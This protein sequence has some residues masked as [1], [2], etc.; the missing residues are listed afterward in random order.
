MPRPRNAQELIH[1]IEEGAGARGIWRAALLAGILVLSLV[2]AWKQFHGPV[3]ESTL[4]QADLGRQLARGE[5][6]TTL[7]N[8]PQTMAFL[9]ARGVRFDPRQPYP[10][11]Y[12]APLYSLAIA[13]ALRLL[14][15]STRTALFATAPAPPDGFGGDYFLLGLNLVLLWLAAWQTYDLG[16]RLFA[17]RV[18]GLAAL[19]LLVSVAVWQQTVAVNGTVLLMVLVLAAFQIWQRIEAAA[20]AAGRAS[21]GWL[22]ALGAVGG[23]L[24]LAEY[25]AGALLL[26]ALGYAGGRFGGRARAVALLAVMVGAI[27]I[28]APWLVRNMRIAGNPVALAAYNLALKAGDPTADPATLR[29]TLSAEAPPLS[30]NKLGNKALTALQETLKSRLWAGGGMFLTAFFVAGWLY[31]FRSRTANRLRWLFVVAFAVLLVAQAGCNSGESECQPA[32][33]L[34]PLV[35][36]FG[37]G[38]FYVLVESSASMVAWPHLAGAVLLAVQ[39]LPLAHDALEPR[40]LHFQY[41]PYFPVQFVGLRLELAQRDPAGRY[42]LMADVPAGAAWYGQL[43]TWAQPLRLRDFYAITFT[44]SIAELLLTPRTLDRPF[45]SE[46]SARPILPEALTAGPSRFGEWG[47]IYAGFLTGRLPP[48]FPLRVPKKWAENL[49]VLYDATLPAPR[50]K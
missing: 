32:V 27:A 31:G 38:F 22:A 21:A 12:H 45:F 7:V 14:P 49:Y 16:R 41:P 5:G 39:A 34:A 23:L 46:L 3:S 18:G 8:Y 37:A 9:Q 35:M 11:L 33:Y 24:F 25:S 1:W 20:D 17:P 2:V 30:L 47:Q 42:G 26:V 50:E 28:T 44:Q 43:R 13:A 15:A 6:F 40:R 4:V 10:E 19:A 36:I 48:E 29:V